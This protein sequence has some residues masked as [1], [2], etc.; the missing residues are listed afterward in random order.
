MKISTWIKPLLLGMTATA[1]LLIGGQSQATDKKH[2]L[3]FIG[4][5]PNKVT[6]SGTWHINKDGSVGSGSVTINVPGPNDI[7]ARFGSGAVINTDKGFSVDLDPIDP[8]AQNVTIS[9]HLNNFKGLKRLN[10]LRAIAKPPA[11]VTPPGVI[12][13]V[14]VRFNVSSLRGLPHI[15][16]LDPNKAHFN[17][18]SDSSNNSVTPKTSYNPST[19]ELSISP[20]ELTPDS[21]F[22]SAGLISENDPLA[23][24]IVEI[25]S[26]VLVDEP[27]DEQIWEF[28][29]T[30]YRIT[31][32]NQDLVT[33]DVTDFFLF[34]DDD[35][36]STF[37]SELQGRLSNV[38]VNNFIGSSFLDSIQ[39]EPYDLFSLSSNLLGETEL[40]GESLQVEAIDIFSVAASDSTQSVPEPS[41]VIA[42]LLGAGIL[43][44]K[45][46]FYC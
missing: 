26:T 4:T 2:V 42:M 7:V 46:R 34:R 25:G 44:S 32:D 31:K 20:F 23:G 45:S 36:S 37:D 5:T 3:N 16:Q 9:F 17:T 14:P 24:A 19:Q 29:P 12:G 18:G 27:L 6:V 8:N 13:A 33:A 1:S 28:T 11:G 10:D 39:N 22:L 38:V 40:N 35:P 21:I 30:T 15:R 41:A 43:G